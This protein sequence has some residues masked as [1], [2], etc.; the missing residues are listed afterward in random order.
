MQ[1]TG[2]GD[3]RSRLESLSEGGWQEIGK[4]V[5]KETKE[6][7]GQAEKVLLPLQLLPALS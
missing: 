6:N 5:E 3:T 1:A 4:V 7:Q 2:L